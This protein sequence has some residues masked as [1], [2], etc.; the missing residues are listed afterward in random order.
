MQAVVLTVGIA[1]YLG[2]AL[3]IWAIRRDIREVNK[4][5]LR[6]AR[7]FDRPPRDDDRGGDQ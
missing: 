6:L 1:G 5:L 3:P 7:F 2:I 4:N